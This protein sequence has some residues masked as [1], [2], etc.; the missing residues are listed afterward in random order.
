MRDI[1]RLFR[2]S[3]FLG[4]SACK[5]FLQMGRLVTLTFL[6]IYLQEHLGYSPFLLGFHI[7]LLH[8]MGILSQPLLSYLSDRFGR[9]AILLPPCTA[10]GVLFYLLA[11]VS[12][13]IQLG[14]VITAIG[15]FFYTLMNFTN[16]AIMDVAG[17]EIQA[18]S[19][20]LTSLV[21]QLVVLPTPIV[22]GYFVG[23][24]GIR[25]AFS[26]AGSFLILV[27]MVLLPLKMYRRLKGI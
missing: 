12:P 5:G 10:M 24:Y 15:L 3:V 4:A 20:G 9:K 23:I 22:A 8:G 1:G 26:L 11:M 21:T 13:G 6:P 18:S 25:F 14:L 17:A 2:N 27:G 7:T 19:Y 16:A